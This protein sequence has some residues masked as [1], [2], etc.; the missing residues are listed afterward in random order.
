M[1]A[2]DSLSTAF[3]DPPREHRSIPLWV[4]NNRMTG[5]RITETLEQYAANGMRGAF[6]HPR[7]GLKNTYLSKEWFDLW[8]FAASEADRLGLELH[9][10]DENSYPS[11]FGG[12]HVYPEVPWAAAEILVPRVA[13]KGDS[14][15]VSAEPFLAYEQRSGGWHPLPAGWPNRTAER[16]T[17]LLSR[18]RDHGTSWTAWQPYVDLARPEV[19]D[20]FLRTTYDR[21]ARELGPH[22]GTTTT[23]FFTDEP[24]LGV[25]SAGAGYGGFP[26]SPFIEREFHR[27]HGYDVAE[28]LPLLFVEGEGAEAVRF[29][30]Y[31]TLHRLFSDNYVSRLA[32]WCK[33]HGV[34]LTGHF[35]EH[36][37][38]YPFITPSS[39]A[40]Q[41]RMHVPGIDLLSMQYRYS[42]PAQSSLFLLTVRELASVGNQCDVRRFCEAHGVTGYE[43]G[44]AT[45]KRLG[46]FLLVNGVD[47][48][49]EHLSFSSIC[50]NRKYDHPATF[51]DHSDWWAHYRRLSD[52]FARMTTLVRAGTQ[53]NRLLVLHPTVTGWTRAAAADPAEG[54]HPGPAVHETPMTELRESQ[55]TL[56]QCLT[57]AQ[58]DFDLGDE[59]I[60]AE[61]GAVDTDAAALLVGSGRYEM[62]LIPANCDTVCASTVRLVNEFLSAGGTVLLVPPGP[63][64][65]NGRPSRFMEDLLSAHTDGIVCAGSSAE[66]AARINDILPRRISTAEGAPL[67]AGLHHHV[68]DLGAGLELHLL[69]ATRNEAWKGVV[70]FAGTGM[71]VFDTRDGSMVRPEVT[72]EAGQVTAPL[73]LG[74]AESVAWLNAELPSARTAYPS[75]GQTTL[76]ELSAVTMREPNR[77]VI[78]LCE[79]SVGDRSCPPQPVVAA[80]RALWKF[81]GMP[82]DLWDRSVQFK[83]SYANLPSIHDSAV[84]MV[85]R[86]WADPPLVADRTPVILAV[87][88]PWLYTVT[89]NGTPVAVSGGE[90]WLDETI[91]GAAV[92]PLLQSGENEIRLS[93]PAFSAEMEVAP[94]YLVG[95]FR[96]R[97]TGDGY[98]LAPAQPLSPGDLTAQGLH[99]YDRSV[100]YSYT[101]SVPE[102]ERAPDAVRVRAPRFHGA[103]LVAK[104]DGAELGE[105]LTPGQTRTFGADALNVRPGAH[106]LTL[107][108]VGTPR[109]LLGPHFAITSDEL[110]VEPRWPELPPGPIAWDDGP[111]GPVSLDQRLIVPFGVLGD[112]EIETVHG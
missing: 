68:R 14:M 33:R 35:M 55:R 89:V 90:R 38:P 24:H 72:T 6:V 109:N 80:N 96:T 40:S 104:W 54:P 10:Y 65:V 64:F 19:T 74:P 43:A 30:Y 41:S 76:A 7:P 4:W 108:C 84:T 2:L 1:T 60:M 15:R 3:R 11:G 49:C 26:Y 32:G 18:A 111:S 21:Y 39:M 46:D 23:L 95:H 31:T 71:T 28:Q 112:P 63:R 105:F 86:F 62:F 107:T 59:L 82:H 110:P 16:R 53:R 102:A 47:L 98:R 85:Y 97:A 56:V 44:F 99:F 81:A 92:G 103:L 78:D 79:L 25:S 70:R 17:L 91:R 52:H 27:D 88:Q 66:I 83:E 73:R 69:V 58:I 8:R 48:L 94:V 37:W 34:A 42:D 57:D 77:A 61:R 87:E 13:E 51:S 9:V 93:A 29:D 50:G 75:T 106:E 100:V 101:V 36:E 22:I 45:F 20:A 5:E 67:P 12:G